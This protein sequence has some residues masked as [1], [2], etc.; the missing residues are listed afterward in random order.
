M[1]IVFRTQRDVER[2]EK[3]SEELL[4]EV[5]RLETKNKTLQEEIDELRQ[6]D[7]AFDNHLDAVEV[8]TWCFKICCIRCDVA[9]KQ[10]HVNTDTIQ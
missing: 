8:N 1:S 5:K 2:T 10:N 6:S 3:G 9:S 4:A 7:N